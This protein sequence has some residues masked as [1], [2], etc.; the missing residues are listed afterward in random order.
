MKK[1]SLIY[2]ALK[3]SVIAAVLLLAF[4][5]VFPYYR[6]VLIYSIR[7][8]FNAKDVQPSTKVFITVMP[9]V[10]LSALILA[11][12][13]RTAREKI[14]F[15]VLIFVLFYFI[16]VFFS[17]LQIFLQNTSIK[18]YHILTVQD[19]FTISLPIVFW[20]LFSYKDLIFIEEKK[21]KIDGER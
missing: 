2:F 21:E 11:T 20:F 3:F 8:F 16:D 17:I 7:V 14:K 5:F 1:D 10:S 12:P 6:Q 13:K 9:Y 4:Y 18:Y 15:I 19:F